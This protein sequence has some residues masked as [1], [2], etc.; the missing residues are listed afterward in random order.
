M[1]EPIDVLKTFKLFSKTEK[2]SVEV[3]G[4]S[5]KLYTVFIINWSRYQ[6]EYERVKKYRGDA[7]DDVDTHESTEKVRPRY[8]IEGEVERERE[9]E[10]TMPSA[11]VCVSK[12]AEEV[13]AEARKKFRRITGKNLGSL[14]QRARE[15]AGLVER[16]GTERVVEALCICAREKKDFMSKSD[17]PLAYFLKN[18]KE[19]LEA[20]DVERE[21]SAAPDPE[22]DN[23][24]SPEDIKPSQEGLVAVSMNGRKKMV[25]PEVARNYISGGHATEWKEPEKERVQ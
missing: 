8:A 19:W 24:P 10:K 22:A 13:Y 25:A 11:P 9:T 17:F 18:F 6:S 4:D 23:S 15:W 3:S 16:E 5:L 21:R 20:V 1:L 14:G 2:I 7:E 12:S